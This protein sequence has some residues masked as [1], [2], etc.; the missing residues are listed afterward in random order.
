MDRSLPPMRW[1]DARGSGRHYTPAELWAYRELVLA[2]IIRDL[3]VRYRQTIIGVA[4]VIVQPVAYTLVFTGFFQLLGRLPTDEAQVPY[5]LMLLSGAI[6]WQA[7]AQGVQQSTLCLANNRQLIT[8]TFFPRLL[9]PMAAVSTPLIDFAIG[10]CLLLAVSLCYGVAP[11]AWFL[12]TPLIA[13]P[14]TCVSFTVG[15]WVSMLNALYRDVSSLVPLAL[16][17]GFISTPVIFQTTVLIPEKYRSVAAVNPLVTIIDLF[18][19]A[20]FLQPPPTATMM[21][22]SLASTAVVL[23]AGLRYFARTED[24]VADRV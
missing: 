23:T 24:I 13:V 20:W 7:F 2:F 4:W 10:W 14:L 8:K 15:T 11:A 17:L 5:P 19:A 12:A 6:V 21:L 22:V 1:S 18:R 3:H 16:Q 9:L